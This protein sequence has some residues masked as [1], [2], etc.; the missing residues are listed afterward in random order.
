MTRPTLASH[1]STLTL[2]RWVLR[3]L[4]LGLPRLLVQEL[5]QCIFAVARSTASP[6]EVST[7]SH[8]RAVRSQGQPSI[9][10]TPP[11]PRAT[12]LLPRGVTA[13]SPVLDHL[14]G[15]PQETPRLPRR[16]LD[17]LPEAPPKLGRPDRT[18][19]SADLRWVIHTSPNVSRR[20]GPCQFTAY[21]YPSR[22]LLPEAEQRRQS[23]VQYRRDEFVSGAP[24]TRSAH[25]TRLA[26]KSGRCGLTAL[27]HNEIGRQNPSDLR[28]WST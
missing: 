18:T 7:S 24:F 17:Q 25:S 10:H 21:I 26:A 2:L 6:S 14:V 16:G 22:Q 28:L 9:S 3:L 12:W 23:P 8:R 11:L 19:G 1:L 15:R 27:G 5:R 20:G 13:G 4:G